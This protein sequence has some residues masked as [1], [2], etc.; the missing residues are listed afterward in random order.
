MMNR[1]DFMDRQE[2]NKAILTVLT[3][4]FKKD[5]KEAHQIVEDAGY[6]IYKYDGAFRV[7]NKETH[8]VV[9]ATWSWYGTYIHSNLRRYKFEN[10]KGKMPVIPFDFV[11]CLNKAIN[12]ESPYVWRMEEVNKA[13]LNYRRI[14][15]DKNSIKYAQERIAKIKKEIAS[16]TDELIREVS[17]LKEAEIRLEN[18]RKDLGLKGVA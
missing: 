13:T 7:A 4:Q 17:D 12:A 10:E 1:T 16:L 2:L 3:T 8:R 11:G 15:H 5:A 6:E 9:Y 18:T 14:S